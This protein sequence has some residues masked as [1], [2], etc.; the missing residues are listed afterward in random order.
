MQ[1][2][3]LFALVTEAKRVEERVAEINKTAVHGKINDFLDKDLPQIL[4]NCISCNLT[5]FTFTIKVDNRQQEHLM[6][7]MLAERLTLIGLDSHRVIPTES[8]DCGADILV[9]LTK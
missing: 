5:Y 2:N 8:E 3:E 9:R 4:R 7:S 6:V 1:K